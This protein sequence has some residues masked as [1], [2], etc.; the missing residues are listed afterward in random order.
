MNEPLYFCYERDFA[1]RWCPVVLH[2]DDNVGG[3]R[4]ERT[5]PIRI[6]KDLIDNCGEA[7]F[8]LLQAAYPAPKED[9]E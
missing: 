6:T 2:G 3:N 8:A 4:V 9:E 1:R 7:R 5:T